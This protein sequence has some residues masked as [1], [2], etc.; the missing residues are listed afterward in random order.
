MRSDSQTRR[1]A[2]QAKSQ[3]IRKPTGLGVKRE[4]KIDALTRLVRL[5]EGLAEGEDPR[6]SRD[7]PSDRLILSFG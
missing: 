2:C 7:E 6:A 1:I 3:T 5:V 4:Q